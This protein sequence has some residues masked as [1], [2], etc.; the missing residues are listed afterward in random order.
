MGVIP[1]KYARI[2]SSI[3]LSIVIEGKLGFQ[4]HC[5]CLP[6]EEKEICVIVYNCIRHD[7]FNRVKQMCLR[8]QSKCTSKA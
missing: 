1:L 8:E 7:A 2:G 6:T 4:H 3:N 5:S